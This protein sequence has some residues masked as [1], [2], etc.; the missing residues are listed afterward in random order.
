MSA[1]LRY[2][3]L[4]HYKWL[5]TALE[6]EHSPLESILLY[7]LLYTL[8]LVLICSC[9]FILGLLIGTVWAVAL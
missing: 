1:R 8:A 5:P 2:T 6:F 7:E 3:D 9:S 4:Y